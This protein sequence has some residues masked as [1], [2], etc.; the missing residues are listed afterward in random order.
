VPLRQRHPRLGLFRRRG[1]GRGGFRSGRW[2]GHNRLQ[3]RH[4]GRSGHLLRGPAGGLLGSPRLLR[5]PGRLLREDALLSLD[6]LGPLDDPA[7]GAH[8]L[9]GWWDGLLHGPLGRAVLLGKLQLRE[10]FPEP[11]KGF[12]GD[13]RLRVQADLVPELGEAI[14]QVP[15]R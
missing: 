15:K 11:R 2:W 5:R 9:R 12:L 6:L 3:A 1:L 7:L 14:D 10:G 4:L 8:R 13:S